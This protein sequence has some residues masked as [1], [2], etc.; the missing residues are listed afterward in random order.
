MNMPAAI[1]IDREAQKWA[2]YLEMQENPNEMLTEILAHK[3]Y[4]LEEEIT[5]L[6]KLNHVRTSRS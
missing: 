1:I 6:R 5:Y 3:V 4:V 2:E